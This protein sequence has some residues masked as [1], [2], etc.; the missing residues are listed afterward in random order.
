MASEDEQVA[1]D[2][3][4]GDFHPGFTPPDHYTSSAS[5]DRGTPH[6]GPGSTFQ[7]RIY[8][9]GGSA[10]KGVARRLN[11]RFVSH[12]VAGFYDPVPRCGVMFHV[13]HH[14]G[15]AKIFRLC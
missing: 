14:P 8:E 13:E 12:S 7:S 11:T 4:G 6:V 1:R 9:I 2:R 3:L 10:K 5:F 15:L